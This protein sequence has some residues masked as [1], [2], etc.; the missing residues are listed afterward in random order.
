MS[1][2][3]TVLLRRAKA[4]DRAA[5][6]ELLPAVYDE[7]HRIAVRQLSNERADHTL[8]PT[9]LVNEAYI[10]LFGDR[11]PDAQDRRHFIGLAARVMRQVLVDYARKRTARKRAG[12]IFVPLF[13]EEDRALANSAG[14]DL[15]L[16]DA[17]LDRLSS[18]DPGLV[19]HVE[20]RYFGG[21]TALE[22]AEMEGQSVHVVRHNLRYAQAWLRR[23]LNLSGA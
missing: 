2:D 8:Q 11:A 23:E 20:L 7:L 4:G 12:G 13:A 22:I 5:L 16:I 6:D 15:T 18:E 19:R 14:A 10:R 3:I 21:M 17:A 9:A 1:L